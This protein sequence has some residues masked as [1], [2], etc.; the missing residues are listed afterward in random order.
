MRVVV[1]VGCPI[2]AAARLGGAGPRHRPNAAIGDGLFVGIVAEELALAQGVLVYALPLLLLL[3]GGLSVGFPVPS[4][5]WRMLPS[6]RLLMDSTH[7]FLPPTFSPKNET[8]L[9]E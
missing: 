1:R 9:N 5:S 6:G 7:F 8:M 2:S 3:L 4:A